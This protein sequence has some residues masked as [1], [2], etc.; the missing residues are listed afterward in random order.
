V[1]G[2]DGVDPTV[3]RPFR[4]RENRGRCAPAGAKDTQELRQSTSGI[5]KEHEPEA[6]N[7]SIEAAIGE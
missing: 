2:Y 3:V 6:A 1:F 7:Q 4:N 5:R